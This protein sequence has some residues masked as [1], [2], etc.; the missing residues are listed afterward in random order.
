MLYLFL[1][2]TALFLAYVNGANDNFKATATVYG[3]GALG[4]RRSL[5]LA[6]A[7]QVCGSLASVFLAGVLVKAFGGKGLVPDGTVANGQFLLAVGIGAAVTV[8]VATRVGLP[9][10]TTHALLGG[11]M[12]AGLV[13]APFELAWSSLS[14]NFVVPL[15]ISPVLAIALTSA[16]YPVASRARRWL[17][18]EAESCVRFEEDAPM[19]VAAGPQPAAMRGGPGSVRVSVGQDCQTQYLGDVFGVS[20]Q[21]AADTLHMGSAFSLGFARGLNDTP[22]V[23]GILM[24]AQFAG[25]GA[26]PT[27]LLVACAMAIGGLIHSRKLAQTMGKRITPMNPGQGLLANWVSSGLV[28]GASFMGAPVSTTHVSTGAIFGIGA[29]TKQANWGL[30]TGIVLAWVGTLP[31]ALAVAYGAGRAFLVLS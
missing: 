27:L 28:I 7:A 31:L 6:T 24:A 29:W 30:V 18:I 20:A 19:D 8:M 14:A 10:S 9:V 1:F 3:A 25:L 22:K 26:R 23:L 15:L 4:Y 12:G 17:G 5:A 11:L 21:Q 2:A 13:F 16:L